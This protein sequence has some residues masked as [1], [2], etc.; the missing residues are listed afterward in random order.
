MLTLRYFYTD[1]LNDPC[2]NTGLCFALDQWAHR[3]GLTRQQTEELGWEQHRA[4]GGVCFPFNEDF[5]E[6]QSETIAETVH[7]N[8]RRI[9]YVKS[10]VPAAYLRDFAQWWLEN[11]DHHLVNGIGLCGSLLHYLKHVAPISCTKRQAAQY[12]AM[13]DLFPVASPYPFNGGDY[14][15]ERNAKRCHL[16][17]YRRAFVQGLQ[18]Q[19]SQD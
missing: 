8:P 16:N 12:A 13:V 17:P 3:K 14:H 10:W 19:T 1:W 7:L 11:P 5:D 2:R 4:L 15:E 18:L 6:Y 9:A